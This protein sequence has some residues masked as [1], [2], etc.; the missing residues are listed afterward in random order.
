MP[1]PGP[2]DTNIWHDEHTCF[3]FNRLSIIDIDNS[4]QPLKWGPPETP[5][6]YWMVF[7]GEVY[8]Y[9]ELR[10][11]LAAEDGAVFHTEGD[12]ESIVA[13][14]HYH[15]AEWV[16]ELRGM[17]SFVIWDSQEDVAFGARDPFG[18]KP[19]TWRRSTTAMSSARRPSRCAHSPAP[20]R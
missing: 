9:L 20:H 19:C 11:R 12:G 16:N 1:A 8:N 15:G 14:Y 5:D 2:D 6:R 13:G 7:N 17:F 3:G 4:G 10:E 18:I